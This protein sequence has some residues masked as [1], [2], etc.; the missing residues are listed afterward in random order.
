MT[1][2]ILSTAWLF[3]LLA[4]FLS[5]SLFSADGMEGPASADVESPFRPNPML[6]L[7]PESPALHP[8]RLDGRI[9]E[10]EWS[11]AAT[12]GNFTE[13][14]PDENRKPLAETDGYVGLDS[15]S[16]LIAF[17]CHDPEIRNLRAN[18]ADRDRMYEDDWVCVS[19]DPD[20]DFQKAYQFYVNPRGIQ[21]DMLFQASG[22]QDQSFDMVWQSESRIL[23]DRWT[24]EMRIPF[25]SLRFPGSD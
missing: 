10:H 21:G 6:I 22:L 11:G 17:V 25:E 16:L 24:A 14:Q 23:E 7:K 19:I 18:F 4:C 13:Y 2:D 5:P 20:R 12:F 15:S 3:T 8:V 9:E 1:R